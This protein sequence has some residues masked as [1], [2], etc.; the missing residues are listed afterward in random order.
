MRNCPEYALTDEAPARESAN[1][2]NVKP[3][4]QLMTF[5]SKPKN[6]KNFKGLKNYAND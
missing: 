3:T 5:K 1:N 2:V 6:V 4:A